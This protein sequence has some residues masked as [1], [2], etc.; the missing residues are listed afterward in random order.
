MGSVEEEHNLALENISNK[1]RLLCQKEVVIED[2]P[3]VK[4][5]VI[6]LILSVEMSRV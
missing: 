6:P 5:I 2:T 3:V 1:F 4:K